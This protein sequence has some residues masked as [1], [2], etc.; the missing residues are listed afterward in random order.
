MCV[1]ICSLV[2]CIEWFSLSFVG[3]SSF[4]FSLNEIND[5][6]EPV[7]PVEGSHWAGYILSGWIQKHQVNQASCS[8]SFFDVCLF[9]FFPFKLTSYC[10]R[11]ETCLYTSCILS[12]AEIE[13][14]KRQKV[15]TRFIYIFFLPFLVFLSLPLSLFPPFLFLSFPIGKN[16]STGIQACSGIACC[17]GRTW[18]YEAARTNDFRTCA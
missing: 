3:V 2:C 5:V 9:I 16:Y 18:I 8:S 6:Q 17:R 4:L 11:I 1:Y 7:F 15:E 10:T 12:L 14:N 13:V